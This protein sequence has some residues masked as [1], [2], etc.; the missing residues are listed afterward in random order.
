MIAVFDMDYTLTQR[1]TWGRFVWRTVRG[2]PWLWLP[3]LASTA[4]KQLAYKRGHQ[5]RCA[6]KKSMMRWSLQSRDR[7]ELDRLAQAFADEEVAQ[8]LRPG[9]LAALDY[10]RARGD[11]IVIA[12]AAADL[13]AAPIAR[14]LG[15]DHLVCTELCWNG[16]T[17][18]GDFASANCYG[19][20][21]RHALAEYVAQQGWDEKPITFY[22]DSHSDFPLIE[23]T[24]CTIIINPKAKTLAEAKARGLPVQCWKVC[25]SGFQPPDAVLSNLATADDG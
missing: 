11:I 22:T 23:M 3:L 2:R 10:H 14:A 18:Q 7:D 9:A 21:K 8:G 1:G 20:A 5:T 19:D 17:L 25:A 16:Q 13:I 4:S 15:I 12:S 6:V 24:D